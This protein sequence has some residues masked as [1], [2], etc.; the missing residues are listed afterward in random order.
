[1]GGSAFHQR[2]RACLAA[3]RSTPDRLAVL[4]VEDAS[5]EADDFADAMSG[6]PVELH[7]HTDAA[8]AL[9]VAG[10]SCPDVIVLGPVSGPIDAVGFLTALRSIDSTVPVVVGAGAGTGELTSR[11]TELAATAVVPRPYRAGELLR[12][13]V[14]LAPRPDR[15]DLRPPVI[16]LGRL[17]IDGTIPQF[18]LDG[19]LVSLPPMEFMLLRY[20]AGRVGSVLSR[21]ELMNA[22]WGE[23]SK[24]HSNTL[25]VHIVRLRKR[26]GDDEQNPHWIKSVRG[27]GYLF[28]VP[29]PTDRP[30][31]Q[32][33]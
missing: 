21:T 12:L 32:L 10:R 14:S 8:K 31:I 2:R 29:E 7:R 28:T 22:V 20:F 25:T 26:L 17:R 6:Q 24:K 33:P 16:N 9:F 19:A 30:S 13:L 18:W 5:R 4:L 11:A 27:L 15:L 1:M 3:A 23:G